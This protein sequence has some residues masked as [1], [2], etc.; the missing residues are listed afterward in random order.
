[1]IKSKFHIHEALYLWPHIMLW[2]VIE[3]YNGA[4]ISTHICP[5]NSSSLHWTIS[6]LDRA[7]WS[8]EHYYRAPTL[9][10]HNPHSHPFPYKGIQS[11]V[12]YT[13]RLSRP[14]FNV[15]LYD[16]SDWPPPRNCCDVITRLIGTGGRMR[17]AVSLS[18][19]CQMAAR[20]LSPLV[21]TKAY[22][23]KKY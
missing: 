10:I 7:S 8:G 2:P 20:S 13:V 5:S 4:D 19:N 15:D 1:M 22:S 11:D 6:T 3:Q 23:L 9:C 12:A 18:L 21:P 17:S 16:S 14:S